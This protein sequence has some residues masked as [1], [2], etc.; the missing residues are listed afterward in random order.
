MATGARFYTVPPEVDSF[1]DCNRVIA[2]CLREVFELGSQE[3]EMSDSKSYNF[4]RV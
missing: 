3:D 1:P 4:N 2:A